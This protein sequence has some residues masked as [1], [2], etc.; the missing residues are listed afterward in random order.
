MADTFQEDKDYQAANES[1]ERGRFAEAME[2]FTKA[3]ERYPDEL[4][5]QKR[6][7]LCSFERAMQR[8]ESGISTNDDWGTVIRN[9]EAVAGSVDDEK[10]LNSLAVACHNLGVLL[11]QQE[12]FEEAQ[13]QF[14]RALEL[15]PDLT[16][17]SINLAIN[18]A[19]QGNPGKAEELLNAVIKRAPGSLEARH[20]LG[21][22]LS[23]QGRE[24]EAVEQFKRAQPPERDSVTVHYSRGVSLL[25]QGE[26]DEAE[27]AFRQALDLHPEFVPA[28]YNLGL[29]LREKGNFPGAEKCF[30]EVIR[31]DPDN[32]G[33]YFCLASL[34]E[35]R[36]PNLAIST[37]EK[38]LEIASKIPGEAEMM[39]K[40]TL[41]LAKLKRKS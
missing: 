30:E 13:K 23:S 18:Y 38:Y 17:T 7:G 22:I 21:L 10:I 2:L 6:L 35:R 31:L 20:A 29:I 14:Q 28:L 19:D 33:G 26:I 37:W 16:N 34:Y 8:L 15:N 39:A 25:N 36:D 40:V 12:A 27:A 1:F 11:N 4:E 41:H 5:V 24:S 3:A 9:L 32:P